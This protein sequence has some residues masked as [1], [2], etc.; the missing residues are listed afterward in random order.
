MSWYSIYGTGA[1]IHGIMP[2]DDE[3]VRFTSWLSVLWIP[4]VPLATWSALYAGERP[5]DGLTDESHCFVDLQRVPHDWGANFTTLF[6]SLLL[7]SIA[8]LPCV[9]MIVLT[10]G[11]AATTPEMVVVFGSTLWACGVILW[12]ERHRRRKLQAPNHRLQLTGDARG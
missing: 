6:C 7:A 1:T 9:I 8:I 5:P 4:I 3:R 12:S 10:D 2:D 11:R